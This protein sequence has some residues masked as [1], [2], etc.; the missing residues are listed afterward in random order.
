[1][2]TFLILAGIEKYFSFFFILYSLFFI[3]LAQR[4]Y[5]F[6]LYRSG[7]D[8]AQHRH[9]KHKGA[10]SVDLGGDACFE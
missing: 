9:G 5:S 7:N 6:S 3:L 4:S 2:V 8:V 1:M 10:Q